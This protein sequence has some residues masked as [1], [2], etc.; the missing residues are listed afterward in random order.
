MLSAFVSSGGHGLGIILIILVVKNYLK[1]EEDLQLESIIRNIEAIVVL[2]LWM[3][4]FDLFKCF[5]LTSHIVEMIAQVFFDLDAFFV[6]LVI[7]LIS[8]AQAF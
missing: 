8:F 6:V 3:L 1:E 4:V 2:F 5:E 7:L